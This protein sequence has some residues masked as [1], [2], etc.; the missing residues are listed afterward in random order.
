MAYVRYPGCHHGHVTNPP[1]KRGH[2]D[3]ATT[4]RRRHPSPFPFTGVGWGA[5]ELA[6]T[7][8]SK[9]AER[10]TYL[11]TDDE[12][13]FYCRSVRSESSVPCKA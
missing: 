1:R 8:R 13:V 3:S 2:A 5:S 6:L 10:G 11:D 9:K 4:D 12:L 7:S